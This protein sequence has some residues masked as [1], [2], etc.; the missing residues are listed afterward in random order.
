MTLQSSYFTVCFSYLAR[1]VCQQLKHQQ[2]R[3]NEAVQRRQPKA[4]PPTLL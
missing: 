4:D 2:D 1:E 3:K